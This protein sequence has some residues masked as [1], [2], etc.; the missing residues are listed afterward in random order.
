MLQINAERCSNLT[1]TSTGRKGRAGNGRS[2]I[3]FAADGR[4]HGKV[5][6]GVGPD[7]LPVRKHVVGS[8]QAAVVRKVKELE[9]IRA[10]GGGATI[11]GRITL[12][13]YLRDWITARVNLGR[14]RPRTIEGYRTDLRRID[15][16]IG[17][18]RLDR[19]SPRNVE[20]LWST[21]VADDV[22]ASVQHCRRTLDAALS[23]A[24]K[25]GLIPRNPVRLATTP[26]YTPSAIE[27]YTLG[28]MAALLSAAAGTRNGVRWT[29]ALALGLRRG[30]ALGLQWQDV[31]LDAGTLTIRRQLQRIPWEHGCSHPAKCGP[32]PD[33]TLRYG[34][35]L[36]SSEP[37][38]LAGRRTLAMPDPLTVELRAHRAAQAAERLAAPAWV[39]GDWVLATELGQPI[40][41]RNDVR[42][43]KRLCRAAGVPERRLHDLRHSAATALLLADVDL[44]T[45]G[46][47]LGHSR[48]EMT[49]RYTHVVADRKR[50]AA[51]R[52]TG[53]LFE[54]QDKPIRERQQTGH[55]TG[56]ISPVSKRRRG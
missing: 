37:K 5:S 45:A 8:T 50:V 11:S 25:Q 26:R 28:E 20:Y 21:M 46:A 35:G 15:A 12:S 2:S 10:E 9:K 3:Y 55:K 4:W 32:A 36:R 30:E 39:D 33:C 56:H 52:M 54:N 44:A 19:L 48:V 6:L 53:V 38:S 16:T 13:P 18:I 31:D 34:G 24:V 43:F 14:V 47:V 27:P 1:M 40:D 7:G 22:L 29:L 41:P 23:E 51:E 49:A 17:H 42:A